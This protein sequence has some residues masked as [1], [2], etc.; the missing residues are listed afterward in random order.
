MKIELSYSKHALERLSSRGISKSLVAQTIESPDS[1]I[2][3]TECK[4]VYHKVFQEGR[5]MKMLRV[6]VNHCKDP[7]LV[8]TAYKTTKIDKYEH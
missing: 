5:N 3:Q 2:N 4:Q 7:I 1:V 8:I 6:F